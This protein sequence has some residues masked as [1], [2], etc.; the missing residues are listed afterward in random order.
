[1]TRRILTYKT[2]AQLYRTDS[3]FHRKYC[4]CL[5]ITATRTL[6]NGLWESLNNTRWFTAP[7]ITFNELFAEVAEDNWSSQKAV[8]RQFLKLSDVLSEMYENDTGD[9]KYRLQAME[10]NQMDLLRTLRILTELGIKPF[11]LTAGKIRLNSA[12]ALFNEV[13]KR[14]Y[15]QLSK[16]SSSLQEFFKI[17]RSAY[18]LLKKALETWGEKL[19]KDNAEG[20]INRIK[21]NVPP[22]N[23]EHVLS[24]S[25]SKKKLVLHGFYFITPIQDR[26]FSKLEE[27]FELVFLNFYD[28]RFP[29]TFETVEHFLGIGK[30]KAEYVIDENARIHPFAAKLLESFEGET[31][32][33]I[34]INAEKYVDLPHF[35]QREKEYNKELE[36]KEYPKK[37]QLI[38][39]RAKEVEEQLIANELLEARASRVKLTDYPVGLFLYRLHQI[40]NQIFDAQ[41]GK[42]MYIENVTSDILLDCFSSGCLVVDGKDMRKYVK[43]L[44]RIAPFCEGASD[45]E[46]WLARIDLLIKEKTAWESK[47]L[48]KNPK[49][50]SDRIHKFHALPMRMLSYFYLEIEEIQKVKKGIEALKSIHSLLF[51]EF[52]TKKVNIASHLQKLEKLVLR[53]AEDYFEGEEK[54]IVRNI[55]EEINSIKDTEL[56]F[57]LK[58]ISKGLLF[59]LN[60][61]F[62]NF[63][64]DESLEGKIESFEG[65]DGVPFMDNR[66][67]HLA[68]V[69]HK[70]LP[71]SQDFNFWPISRKLLSS[72]EKQFK[73]LKLF[74]DRKHLNKSITKYL[75]YVLFHNADNIRI[76]FA[77]N[78]GKETKL[79]L[80][81]YFKL[82]GCKIKAADRENFQS[83]EVKVEESVKVG[84]AELNWTAPMKREATVCP[85]RAVFS[86][87]LNEHTVFNSDFHHK[88]LYTKYIT[89]MNRME[90]E[91][92]YTPEEFKKKI[93]NWFPQWGK[94]KKE[95][96]YNYIVS[97]RYK[98]QGSNGNIIEYDGQYYS[99]SLYFISLIPSGTAVMKEQD[100]LKEENVILQEARS[101]K[102][103]R[104]CPYISLCRE[105]EYSIDFDEK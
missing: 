33:E 88:F 29:S 56:N 102:H 97:S 58:D 80:A 1:M 89:V 40:K 28:E 79:D 11:H 98:D 71:V 21:S 32:V 91:K 100:L 59:Y 73:E 68:F 43:H 16:D 20:T 90:I 15:I 5:H 10:R 23:I 85:K 4:D 6:K 103:C 62:E 53:R 67:I 86:F 61:S 66:N 31:D 38:T 18:D 63:E 82:A 94:K 35:I 57:S 49:A 8:L 87:V 17:D 19:Y 24:A 76:S 47:V 77:E 50:L 60:G 41:T 3:L 30:Y 93:D 65:A 46:E 83:E 34:D 12:E 84:L 36:K 9:N 78:I 101:G 2:P 69:D 72:L 42:I 105:A 48:E 96:L 55:I 22:D 25:I 26:V 45:F 99:D 92:E 7:L 54:A 74:T 95:F 37:Y 70:A 75:L 13:W 52:E 44:E 27:D 81:L 51:D 104:Y 14:M 64:K 39:S